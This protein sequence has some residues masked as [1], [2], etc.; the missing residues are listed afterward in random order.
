MYRLEEE[1]QEAYFLEE[2]FWV[3]ECLLDIIFGM[4]EE[5]NYG[6]EEAYSNGNRYVG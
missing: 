6:N 1:S 3:H 4:K 5:R 2:G